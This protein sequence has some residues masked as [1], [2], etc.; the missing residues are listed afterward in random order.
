M[1]NQ[2]ISEIKV[3]SGLH[4]HKQT[5]ATNWDLNIYRG[6]SHKCKYCFAQYTHDYLNS[7]NFFNQIF[8]KINIPKIL[9]K[10]LSN[11]K[12]K[13]EPINL[14]GVSDPYQPAE[15]SYKLMPKILKIFLKHKNPMVITTK[16]TLILRDKKLINELNKKTS[17]NIITSVSTTNENIRKLIEPLAP[18]TKQRIKMLKYFKSINCHTTLLI[19]PIIPYLTDNLENL[20][21]LFN[22]ARLNQFDEVYTAPLHLRGNVKKPFLDFIKTHF[23][24]IFPKIT[25]LYKGAYV[26]RVYRIELNKKIKYLRQKYQ[27]KN[28][29]FINPEQKQH[30]L[31]EFMDI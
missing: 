5:F 9:D 27:I 24:N 30:T 10:E 11:P 19:M 12:W 15:A 22:I 1:L 7:P 21:S 23:P 28:K 14:S 4:F 18:P 25:A 13:K 8:V 26:S 29:P 31:Q 20:E 2:D 3:K 6:C 17:V 16:S